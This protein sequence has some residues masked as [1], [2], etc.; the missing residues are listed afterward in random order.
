MSESLEEIPDTSGVPIGPRGRAWLAMSPDTTFLGMLDKFYNDESR[1]RLGGP[2]LRILSDR[3]FRVYDRVLPWDGEG[4]RSV[5]DISRYQTELRRHK[6]SIGTN[7]AKVDQPVEFKRWLK[8]DEQGQQ[9][10]LELR[11]DILFSGMTAVALQGSW[12]HG[13]NVLPGHIRIEQKDMEHRQ[14]LIEA[15]D[16][17]VEGMSSGELMVENIHIHAPMLHA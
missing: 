16:E 12:L 17:L 8:A 4:A 3:S 6:P 9:G 2:A 10:G 14:A 11:F 13:N 7:R 5:N 15:R 1:S